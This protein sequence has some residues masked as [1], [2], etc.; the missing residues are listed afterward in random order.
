MTVTCC[1]RQSRIRLQKG[2]FLIV[3]DSESFFSHVNQNDETD[4]EK[5]QLRISEDDRKV[6]IWYPKS[7]IQRSG[8][9]CFEH[10]AL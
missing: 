10:K 9:S 7:R 5:E 4:D 2:C 6:L 1:C 8:F 3:S